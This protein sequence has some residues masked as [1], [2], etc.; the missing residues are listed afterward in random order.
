MINKTIII[1]HGPSLFNSNLGEWIDSHK[2]VVRFPTLGDWQKP[3]DHGSRTSHIFATSFRM[4]RRHSP[5]PEIGYYIWSKTRPNV[6][7]EFGH[8][9]KPVKDVTRLVW[10]WEKILGDRATYPRMSHGSASS[11]I[12]MV[13]LRLPVVLVGCDMLKI[14]E[15]SQEKYIGSYLYENR[16]QNKSHHDLKVERELIDEMSKEYNVEFEFI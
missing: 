7:K 3:K 12:A 11:L 8:L 6:L 5:I 2:Y 9:S 4:R 14:G 13:E 15:S 10:K 1:G 16:K